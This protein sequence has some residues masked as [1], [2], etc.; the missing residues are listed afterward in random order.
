MKDIRSN[1]FI[2]VTWDTCSEGVSSLRNLWSKLSCA[3][4]GQ[5]FGEERRMGFSSLDVGSA[6]KII[7]PEFAQVSQFPGYAG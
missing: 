2:Y 3:S 7:F 4:S 6:A 1:Y 5:N